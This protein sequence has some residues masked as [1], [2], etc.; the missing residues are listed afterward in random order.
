MFMYLPTYY[1][2]PVPVS[3]RN[4]KS[5]IRQVAHPNPQE[6]KHCDWALAELWAFCQSKQIRKIG[7]RHDSHLVICQIQKGNPPIILDYSSSFAL[8]NQSI[9][10]SLPIPSPWLYPLSFSHPTAP[11]QPQRSTFPPPVTNLPTSCFLLPVSEPSHF[12]LMP[13]NP[14]SWPSHCPTEVLQGLP[15]VYTKPLILGFISPEGTDGCAKSYRKLNNK[16]TMSS[17][18][19]SGA[20]IIGWKNIF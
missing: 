5:E 8:N 19:Y 14:F 20:Q 4:R 13:V 10:W 9:T 17:W 15:N 3:S 11:A 16:H 2:V 12:S 1:T 6:H 7:W 18:S